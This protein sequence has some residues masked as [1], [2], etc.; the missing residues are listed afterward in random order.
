M[1]F[2]VRRALLCAVSIQPP[3]RWKLPF[4]C[5]GP[6]L[7]PHKHK[8][9]TFCFQGPINKG[10]P[11]KLFGRILMFLSQLRESLDTAPRALAVQRSPGSGALLLATAVREGFF[12]DQTPPK[13]GSIW[14]FLQIGGPLDGCPY[15]KSPIL[16]GVYFRAP[17]TPIY[18]ILP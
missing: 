18:H 4:R 2:F 7:R 5:F 11:E 9:I 1:A 14:P 12:K 10:I 16:L 3:D 15:S 13:S 8:D 6:L 17:E